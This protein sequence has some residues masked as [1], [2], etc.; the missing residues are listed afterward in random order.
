VTLHLRPEVARLSAYAPS[1]TASGAI[2]LFPTRRDTVFAPLPSVRAAIEQVT[3]NAINSYANP[4]CD[5]LKLALAKHLNDADPQARKHWTSRHFAVGCG[6]A[7]LCQQLIQITTTVGDEVVFGWPSFWLYARQVQVA[8][9]TAVQVPLSDHT[10]DL[11]SMLAAVT[12]RTRLIFVCN[13]NNPTSTVVDPDALTR[14]VQAL[15]PQILVAIDEAYVDYVRDG[16]A[17]LASLRL[18]RAHHNVVVLRTFSKAYGLAGLRVGYAISDPDV[19]TALEKVGVPFSVTSISRAAAI[20]SLAATDEMRERADVVVA[21]RVRVSAALRDAGF[22]LPPSQTSF[23]WLPLGPR[24]QDF[25][26]RAADAGIVVRACAAHGV[27]VTVGAPQENDAF[28]R[29][30]HNWIKQ[31]FPQ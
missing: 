30:A 5:E 3:D 10:L 12:D 18:V 4:G 25:V 13:P 6:S 22:R 15:S 28:L 2:E 14:F 23:V 21:E 7:S 1:K 9:A 26:E 17:A 8:G 11:D 27:P 20:A 29:F 31:A 24:T 16:S 19:I